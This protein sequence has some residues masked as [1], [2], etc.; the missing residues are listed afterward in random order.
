MR[1]VIPQMQLL[2]PCKD[3]L[4][5]LFWLTVLMGTKVD[6]SSLYLL[7]AFSWAYIFL[8]E[9]NQSV[10]C[11]FKW[12]DCILVVYLS[13]QRF[14]NHRVTLCWQ[15]SCN[16]Q[17]NCT[18][19]YRWTIYFLVVF[20]TIWGYRPI[21]MHSSPAGLWYVL[22]L[23]AYDEPFIFFW[24]VI[25]LEAFSLHGILLFSILSNQSKFWFSCCCCWF[26]VLP[27]FLCCMEQALTVV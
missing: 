15:M 1:Q 19:T 8:V 25:P 11:H 20:G 27:P 5:E 24:S 26:S 2:D 18:K 4:Y 9:C 13:D 17:D 22:G 21:H 6:P 23:Y 10:S 16:I 7:P 3:T 14:I 12:K